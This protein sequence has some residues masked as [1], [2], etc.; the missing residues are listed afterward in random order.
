MFL[1][2][3]GQQVVVDTP[4]SILYL[5]TLEKENEDT[6]EIFDVDVHDM[7]ESLTSKEQYIMEAARDGIKSNRRHCTIKQTAII[8]ISLLSDILIFK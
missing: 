5:G 4:Y 3:I 2:F 1:K 8:S 6:I 7:T